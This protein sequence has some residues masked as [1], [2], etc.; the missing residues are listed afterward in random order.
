MLDPDELAKAI[1]QE[2]GEAASERFR[3][4]V[5]LR[6]A[7]A[8]KGGMSLYGLQRYPVTLYLAQW[9]ALLDHAELIRSFL[10]EHRSELRLHPPGY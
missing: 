10:E 9:E 1:D 8:R 7:V 6:C 3:Y 4:S 5:R 2:R